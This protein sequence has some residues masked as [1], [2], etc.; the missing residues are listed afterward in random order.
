[1]DG[2][3]G[4][5]AQGR[6]VGQRK[7]AAVTGELCIGVRKLKK[8]NAKIGKK[9]SK[10]AHADAGHRKIGWKVFANIRIR[11]IILHNVHRLRKTVDEE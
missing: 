9:Y 2:P 5:F 4:Q 8:V 7:A 1:M 3:V 6:A 10:H 11:G